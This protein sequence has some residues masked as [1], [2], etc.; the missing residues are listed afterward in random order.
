MPWV[1]AAKGLLG[2]KSTWITLVVILG[3]LLAG[4][5][6]VSYV[7]TKSENMVLTTQLAN[8][9]SQL[10]Q[11]K[12]NNAA[13][14]KAVNT[15]NE[16]INALATQEAPKRAETIKALKANPAWANQPIPADVLASL[17]E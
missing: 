1:L 16:L 14:I 10:N 12:A 8:A 4:Y 3:V 17:R 7:A 6:I 15:R 2:K 5:T 13:N 11:V 9:N